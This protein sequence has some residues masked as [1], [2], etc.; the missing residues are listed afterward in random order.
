[1]PRRLTGGPGSLPGPVEVNRLLRDGPSL[2]EKPE[3][4]N[5]QALQRYFLPICSKINDFL[6][7]GARLV[8][9]LLHSVHTHEDTFHTRT[10]IRLH[11]HK[12]T[13][14]LT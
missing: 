10:Y 13:H 11:T 6:Y 7:L 12:C 14:T 4:T 8:D 9:S 2:D 3:A 5:W 1:M